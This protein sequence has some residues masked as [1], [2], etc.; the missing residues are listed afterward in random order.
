VQPLRALGFELLGLL[1]AGHRRKSVC[2]DRVALRQ[3]DD[4]AGAQVDGGEDG[5]GV[6]SHQFSLFS[7]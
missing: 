5:K 3:A 2:R 6:I 4:F 1:R 7:L